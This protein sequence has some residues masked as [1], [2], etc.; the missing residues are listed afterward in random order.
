[1]EI[2]IEKEIEK[3]ADDFGFDRKRSIGDVA[4]ELGL[5]THVI[6]F[7]EDNF[8]QIKP[9]IGKGGRRYYYNKQVKILKSIK[10]FLYEDGYTIAGLQKML[11]KR[12]KDDSSKEKEEDLEIIANFSENDG[13]IILAQTIANLSLAEQNPA[14]NQEK[15]DLVQNFE[16]K[17]EI[18]IDD[19][20]SNG[21]DLSH[22]PHYNAAYEAALKKKPRDEILSLMRNI[23]K[24]LGELKFLLRG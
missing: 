17:V 19:F 15:E 5:E 23:S 7:W 9:E 11:K 13:E 4:E 1:M 14:K 21:L 18:T 3:M 16:N 2:N 10:K 6:R 8:E 12:R 20:I 22:N 24:N